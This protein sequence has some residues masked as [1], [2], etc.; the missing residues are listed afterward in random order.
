MKI[1][2]LAKINHVI[3]RMCD[4]ASADS[5]PGSDYLVLTEEQLFSE[6]IFCIYSSQMLYELAI[7]VVERLRSHGLT[8]PE[9]LC[10]NTS[11]C[12]GE[13]NH[14]LSLPITIEINGI[15]RERLP[16]MKNRLTRMTVENIKNIYCN[17]NS[18]SSLLLHAKSSK[19]ARRILI[20]NVLGFGPKQAS[21]YLRRVGYANDLAVI[22]THILS[23][24]SLA[25]GVNKDLVS[26][27][28]L[29]EY[30][31]I[32]DKFTQVARYF[33]RQVGEVDL[34]TWITMRVIKSDI[35]GG[36]QWQ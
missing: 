21:L 11:K 5:G 7:A 2:M 15:S 30:E 18:F 36:G 23:Y 28:R 32:E 24:L 19:D 33:G 31:F 1:D 25:K 34:A 26:L 12:E 10:N 8:N 13:I 22:D 14:V 17:N 9:Y 4:E 35:M 16:R 20:D 3:A 6:A 29:S 27:S